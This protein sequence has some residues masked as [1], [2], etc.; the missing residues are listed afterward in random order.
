MKI[1]SF[2]VGLFFLL[3]VMPSM[4]VVAGEPD[5]LAMMAEDSEIKA[6]ATVSKV[7]IM[8][9]NGDG[10]FKRVTFK[11]IYAVTPYTPKSFIGG[12][13]TLESAWQK[14]GDGMVYFKPKPGQ[15]VFV[16]I[17]SNGGA[18]TSFTPISPELDHVV[19]N[20]PHRLAYSRGKASILPHQ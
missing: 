16:T 2:V 8:S 11:R 20:E 12:C 19:R 5:Y 18:I 13:K 6:I 14:R 4:S 9:R 10:T 15:R 1:R 7:K 3:A 17:T